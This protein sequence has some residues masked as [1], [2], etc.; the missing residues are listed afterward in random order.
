MTRPLVSIAMPTYNRRALLEA[1]VDSVRAQTLDDFEL[2]IVDDASSDGTAEMLAATA[3]ADRRVRA[4]RVA[5]NAGCDAARNLAMREARGRYLAFLDD[6]DL[7]LPE[8]LERAVARFES[9]NELGVVFSRFGLIDAGGRPLPWSPDFLP[10]G[11][12]PVAGE[13]VFPMLYCDW[14]WIPTC[15][16]TVRA[17]RIAGLAF[18]EF[19]RCDNDAVFNAQ[20]AA[21]GA[22][23]AQVGDTLAL[24]RRDARY[25]SM[26]RDRQ[27]LLADRRASLMFLRRW[28]AERGITAF[29]RLHGRAWSN[30]LIKEAELLGGT[31]GLGRLVLAIAHWPGNPRAARYIWRRT[32]ARRR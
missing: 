2:L 3:R 18:P 15:T 6:D 8:R 13:R 31:Q 17:E 5:V 1:A 9:H 7:F 14:G 32:F 24:V 10:I 19:R 26:S 11:E 16:L 27:A 22:S 20:L 25:A 23:F 28:L 30:H 29:D 12:S 21:T 4:L